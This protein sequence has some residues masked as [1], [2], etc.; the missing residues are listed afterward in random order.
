MRTIKH[1][2]FY[3]ALA[4]AFLTSCTKDEDDRIDLPTEPAGA[5]EKG[6]LI[7]NEG[8]FGSGSGTITYISEDLETVDQGIYKKVNGGDLGNI[9]NG[10]GF[11]AIDAY[12]VA[13]NSNRVM[14]ADRYTFEAKGSI[15]SGLEN[16]RHFVSTDSNTG[17]ISN[18]GDPMD[19]EDDFIA[20]VDLTSNSVSSTISVPFG[21][22]KMFVNNNKVYVAHKGGYGHHHVVSVISG[23]QVLNTITVGDT[24]DSMV[25]VGNYLY[26]LGSGKPD[27]TG[28]E[29]A[30][31]LSKI[32]LTTDQVIERFDFEMTQHPEHLAT[33]GVNLYYNLDG[34]VYK[35]SAGSISSAATPI[36]D[37]YFYAM[38]VNG[39]KLYG[40]D[41]KDY[42]S[43][44]SLSVFDLSNNAL[45]KEIE[46]GIIP[47][48]IYFNE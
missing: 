18:W 21:P 35:L 25:K 4:G 3:L 38:E 48:G 17:Y 30:G 47:G 33:D 32:D 11:T 7:S 14:V 31:S 24:P 40:T 36:I 34:R 43:K 23:N 16:P 42:A 28:D 2:L 5:Y 22:E 6:I 41:A 8:P 13:N 27:Y 19:E 45:M 26:V 1:S 46:V 20:V 44:G 37:G 12:V 9:V 29:T 39:G 10:M 15:T